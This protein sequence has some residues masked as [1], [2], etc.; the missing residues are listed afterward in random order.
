MKARDIV[1]VCVA[2]CA[3]AVA[4]CG[5]N[6]LGKGYTATATIHVRSV[7]PTMLSHPGQ[8]YS[9]KEYRD[10]KETQRRL[11]TSQIVLMCALRKPDIAKL[12]SVEAEIINGDPVRWLGK[13]R[14]VE[15]PGDAE[16]MSVSC[17]TDNPHD[18]AALTNA[19]VDAYM[20][21]VVNTEFEYRKRKL[22]ELEQIVAEKEK[23]LIEKRS[24]LHELTSMSPGDSAKGASQKLD[25]SDVILFRSAIKSLERVLQDVAVEREKA[26]IEVRAPLRIAVL[27]PA[28]EP[29]ERD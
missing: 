4:G 21:E 1:L 14:K 15:F 13:M 20:T 27:E 6:G 5:R 24:E 18:A 11:V 29:L 22:N 7:A 17:T 12:P 28:V 10:Y 25:S 3:V 26:Q 23:A 2:A 9:E 16:I 8:A 19:V